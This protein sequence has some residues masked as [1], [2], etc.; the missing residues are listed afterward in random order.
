LGAGGDELD[1]KEDASGNA[2]I[3]S[4]WDDGA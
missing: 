1:V 2:V 3:G 4:N